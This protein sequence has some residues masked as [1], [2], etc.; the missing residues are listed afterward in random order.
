[1]PRV[2]V[3][4]DPELHFG[5]AYNSVPFY[6]TLTSLATV[7][8]G[9]WFKRQG[10]RPNQ[11]TQ[12]SCP[13]RQWR[14]T[15]R[16]KA[17][18]ELS[19]CLAYRTLMSHRFSFIAAASFRVSLRCLLISQRPHQTAHR[20]SPR[21]EGTAHSAM[22]LA[23]TIPMVLATESEWPPRIPHTPRAPSAFPLLA[24]WPPEF[25]APP[26]PQPSPIL[27]L[28]L[29]PLWSSSSPPASNH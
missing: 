1:M 29:P 10:G 26:S 6:P 19:F 21:A 24:Q 14:D 12:T 25:R 2:L 3:C 17:Q 22:P 27:L 8:P 11:S 15:T 18:H 23:H 4:T 16:R 7:L 28:L 20:A 13:T 5:L 9:Q